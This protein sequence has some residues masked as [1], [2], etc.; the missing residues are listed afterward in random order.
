MLRPCLK[1]D[2]VRRQHGRCHVEPA[3]ATTRSRC[4]VPV[5]LDSSSYFIPLS[6][7]LL[8]HEILKSSEVRLQLPD[9]QEML[10][11]SGDFSEPLQL[12]LASKAPCACHDRPTALATLRCPQM[13]G[14]LWACSEAVAQAVGCSSISW[15]CKLSLCSL[16]SAFVGSLWGSA[17]GPY[18]SQTSLWFEEVDFCNRECARGQKRAVQVRRSCVRQLLPRTLAADLLHRVQLRSDLQGG[19]CLLQVD[20]A[21]FARARARARAMMLSSGARSSM[22]ASVLRFTMRL[23]DLCTERQGRP[24]VCGILFSL[25]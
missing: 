7:R 8:D 15:V 10:L 25:R 1:E 16:A 9:L 3:Q 13:G 24:A 11:A 4:T 12:F 14:F 6:A 5:D 20:V 22:L 21:A 19:D 2:A 18:A 17:P 23:H